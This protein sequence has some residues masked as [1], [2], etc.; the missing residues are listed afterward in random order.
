MTRLIY[1]YVQM[2]SAS[3][4]VRVWLKKITIHYLIFLIFKFFLEN[5]YMEAILQFYRIA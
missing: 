3:L 4:Q 2:Q 5:P 1:S